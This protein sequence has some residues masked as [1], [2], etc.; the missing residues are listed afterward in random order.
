MSA[1]QRAAVAT[2]FLAT[3]LVYAPFLDHPFQ[4]DDGHTLAGHAALHQPDAWRAALTGTTLS[5][6]ET[7]RQEKQQAVPFPMPSCRARVE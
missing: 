2:L 7:A 5:S 4:Y 6:A 3:I 1:V